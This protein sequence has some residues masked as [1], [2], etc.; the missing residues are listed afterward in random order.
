MFRLKWDVQ[1]QGSGRIL[2]VMDKWGGGGGGPENW[3]IFMDVICVSSLN[4]SDTKIKRPKVCR[5]LS[6]C[7][8]LHSFFSFPL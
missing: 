5:L 6:Q 8:I 2:D 7:L 1:G 3:K 4:H